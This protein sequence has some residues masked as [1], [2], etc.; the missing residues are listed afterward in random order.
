MIT[1]ELSTLFQVAGWLITVTTVIATLRTSL[2]IVKKELREVSDKVDEAS[3]KIDK[4]ETLLLD[5]QW[6]V[7]FKKKPNGSNT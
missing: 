3:A 4:H 2:N 6:A 5:L 7:G 1:I